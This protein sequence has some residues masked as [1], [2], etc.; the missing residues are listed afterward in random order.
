MIFENIEDEQ[1]K[2]QS[3]SFIEKSVIV[4][5]S[6]LIKTVLWKVKKAKTYG[7]LVK[8]GKFFKINMDK[9]DKKFKNKEASPDDFIS[10]LENL[11]NE[12]K[13]N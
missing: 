1:Y 9:M 7:D 13:E 11:D 6:I 4:A 5:L 8:V 2:D 12:L 3:L 10:E